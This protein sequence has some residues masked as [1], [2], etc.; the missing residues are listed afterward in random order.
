VILSINTQNTTVAQEK[1]NEMNA[2]VFGKGYF[3]EVD[4]HLITRRSIK[5]IVVD[6]SVFWLLIDQTGILEVMDV[7]TECLLVAGKF[8]IVTVLDELFFQNIVHGRYTE[9]FPKHG[10]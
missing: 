2:P 6:P 1:A 10:L 5:N 3:S 4:Q 7:I 9:I 8:L